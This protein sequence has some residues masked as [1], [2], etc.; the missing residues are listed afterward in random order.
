MFKYTL[1]E[2]YRKKGLPPDAIPA[3]M[4]DRFDA[5]FEKKY[6]ESFLNLKG[7]IQVRL[8]ENAV[9]F[10]FYDGDPE[11]DDVLIEERYQE[12]AYIS[13]IDKKETG[14]DILHFKKQVEDNC[15]KIVE[16]LNGMSGGCDYNNLADYY[17]CLNGT[18]VE[19]L[20]FIFPFV[21]LFKDTR[22]CLTKNNEHDNRVKELFV[23]V[24]Q[25]C[26][27]HFIHDI[28]DN[29]SDFAQSPH[30]KEVCEKLHGSMVYKL[31]YAKL[32]YSIYLYDKA[33]PCD[34]D[35]YTKV[36]QQF[37]D[38]LMDPHIN[39]I[40]SPYN[41]PKQGTNENTAVQMWF[42]N[43]EEEL[44]TILNK[45]R[46]YQDIDVQSSLDN[47]IVLKISDFLYTKH[48]VEDALTKTI[49]KSYFLL[50]QLL[51]G[52]ASMPIIVSSILKE[53]IDF[54]L[55]GL[56]PFFIL[57]FGI[58]CCHISLYNNQKNKNDYKYLFIYCP[59]V[60]LI[61]LFA[62]YHRIVFLCEIYCSPLYL[63]VSFYGQ[64]S[65]DGIISMRK[66]KE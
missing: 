66:I 14:N 16:D 9:R 15:R 57:L 58:F 10:F 6:G 42:Y 13:L 37:A 60:I 5:I 4:H 62:Y 36:T 26:L 41:Y 44:E 32:K 27:L 38:L 28:E 48:D 8:A 65:L 46:K 54:C 25:C 56:F 18:N 33:S 22:S 43:P 64:D 63:S 17:D 50:A 2:K 59:S 34:K 12:I 7:R 40:I 61:P 49:S 19:R 39:K 20:F 3:K 35:R 24:M 55:H 11:Y 51:M 23:I 21:E 52:I 29:E 31:L 47:R 30:Y 1:T 53:S 45:D